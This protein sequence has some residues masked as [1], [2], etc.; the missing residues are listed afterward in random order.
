MEL[1]LVGANNAGKSNLLRALEL[2]LTPSTSVKERDFHDV[3]QHLGR[4]LDDVYT[5][6]RI[7]SALGYLTPAEFEAQWLAYRAAPVA[8]N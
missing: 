7:H 3:Y 1:V 5:H 6:K 4:F 2:P 8:A